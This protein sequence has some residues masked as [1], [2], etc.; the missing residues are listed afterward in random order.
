MMILPVKKPDYLGT[1]KW[2]LRHGRKSILAKIEDAK[3][4]KKFQNREVDV[5]PGDTL[6]CMVRQEMSYG[7]DN[8]LV[9]ENYVII[10]VK[11]VL[12]NQY[13]RQR[14]LFDEK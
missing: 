3:W 5:R 7:Y 6:R 14:S 10:E 8:E 12:E 4:L 1:S 9:A 11:E 13:N 2:E